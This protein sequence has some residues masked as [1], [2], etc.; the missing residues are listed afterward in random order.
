MQAQEVNV[1]ITVDAVLDISTATAVLLKVKGPNDT[2]TRN[3]TMTPSGGSNATRNT[4]VT[5]FP[6][7]GTYQTQLETTLPAGKI[8][9]SAVFPLLIG[10]AL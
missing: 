3:L 7:G 6:I 2:N 10:D 4:V 9:K 1:T 5:D 8:F